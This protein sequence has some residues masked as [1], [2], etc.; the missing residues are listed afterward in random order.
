[1]D[2]EVFHDERLLVGEA[3]IWITG[4]EEIWFVDVFRGHLFRKRWGGGATQRSSYSGYSRFS[5]AVPASDSSI[6]FG[7]PDGIGFSASAELRPELAKAV[8]PRPDL[9][10][11]DGKAD[12]AGR[13]VF[14]TVQN[15]RRPEGSLYSLGPGLALT[16]LVEGGIG[17]SN[18]L[19]WS[20]DGSTFYYVDS[21][22]QR[23]D[24]FDY[25]VSSG[26]ALNR[27]PFAEIAVEDGLPDGLTVDREGCVWVALYGGGALHRYS[28]D[29]QLIEV[30]PTPVTFPASC[31]FVGPALDHLIVTS[32]HR[33]FVNEGR[34]P[35]DLDGMVL[36]APTSTQGKPANTVA[37]EVLVVS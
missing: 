2:F 16:T 8:D 11:N 29:G 15:E 27:R 24:M 3:P 37:T 1:M 32:A 25:D 34:E 20:P 6:V 14:G 23:I 26:R 17:V 7:L 10:L 36:I 22:Q 19:D 9:F 21:P 13:L 18:G 28:P 31:A 4:S 30:V 35:G 5:F 12:P 33:V